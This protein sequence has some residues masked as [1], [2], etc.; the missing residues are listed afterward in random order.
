[1]N[2]QHQSTQSGFTLIEILVVVAIIGM[3]SI[4]VVISLNQARAKGRDAKRKSDM[5]Q[6]QK[7]LELYANDNNGTYPSTSMSWWGIGD[8]GGNR[9]TSGANA[10]IPDLTPNYISILPVDPRGVTTGWSG[11]LYKSNGFSYKL[12]DNDVGPE[13]FPEVNEPFYDP[14]RPTTAWAVWSGDTTDCG[15][16]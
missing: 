8:E 11:Y 6:V 12:I 10:Y 16:W 5:G 9:D 1:M 4:V 3:L 15:Q 13:S 2:K 14:C 7:A